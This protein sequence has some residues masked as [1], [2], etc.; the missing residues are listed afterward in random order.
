[1]KPLL[2]AQKNY[3]RNSEREWQEKIA[4]EKN[5]LDAERKILEADQNELVYKQRLLHR[6]E[7]SLKTERL[8]LGEKERE[9]ESMAA[10]FQKEVQDVEQKYYSISKMRDDARK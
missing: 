3:A 1:M 10:V 4:H 8:K 5:Q 9:I 6:E 2:E 7:A